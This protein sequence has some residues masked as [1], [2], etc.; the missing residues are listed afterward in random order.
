[1]KARPRTSLAVVAHQR[2]QGKSSA[3]LGAASINGIPRSA[4]L[5]ISTRVGG[6]W[7]LTVMPRPS[8]SD[9]KRSFSLLP[10]A[11]FHCLIVR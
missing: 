3:T 2:A 11:Q 5:W 1:M 10:K 6:I 9:P 4:L 7:L 8:L